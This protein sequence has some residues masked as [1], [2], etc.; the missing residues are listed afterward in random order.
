MYLVSVLFSDSEKCFNR[1]LMNCVFLPTLMVVNQ[2]LQSLVSS[3]L[4]TNHSSHQWNTCPSTGLP[5]KFPVDIFERKVS[6][7]KL[8]KMVILSDHLSVSVP[9][10]ISVSPQR[11]SC[12][13]NSPTLRV[14]V[15]QVHVDQYHATPSWILWCEKSRPNLLKLVGFVAWQCFE[16]R[17]FLWAILAGKQCNARHSQDFKPVQFWFGAPPGWFCVILVY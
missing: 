9:V 7:V 16:R 2:T 6:S 13:N 17:F 11:I 3:C 10:S 14:F 4:L 12:T 15:K 1:Q 8:I 5:E